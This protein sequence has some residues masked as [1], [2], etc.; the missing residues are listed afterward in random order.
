MKTFISLSVFSLMSAVVLAQN[1]LA[2]PPALSGATIDLELQNGTVQFF[3]GAATNT[4][5]ANGP[6]LGP[7]IILDRLQNVTMNVT[8]SLG[9]EATIHWHGMH[10]PAAADGGP[11]TVIPAGTTWSPSFQVLDKAATH[12]YHPHL[13]MNTNTQVQQG[14]AGMIIVRDPEEQAL[15]L[16]RSYGVDDF[17]IV[18]QTKAFDANN[19]II[20]E[21]ALDVNVMVNGTMDPY[22]DAPAQMIRLRLLNGASERTFNFGFTND[23]PFYQI[24]SDGSLLAAPVTHTRLD[25]SP[26]ERAEVVVD[27]SGMQ[28]QTIFLQSF[29]S[30]L[31]NAVYGATQPG[32]GAGQVIPN[33]TSNPLNGNDFNI[34]QINVVAATTDPVPVSALPATL[35]THTPWLA[36]EADNMR[37]FVFEPE[38][39]GPGAINGPF[40][41]NNAMFDMDIINEIVPLD[42]IEIWELTNMSPIGHPFHLHDVSFY[43]LTID[44]A[45][46]PAHLQG[47]KD[48]VFVPGGGSVVQFI[49]KFEDFADDMYPYMYHCHIL[50]HEDMGM[51]GQF[52][53]TENVG[54]DEKTPKDFAVYPN[55]SN[56]QI[57][58]LINQG[59][60]ATAYSIA[61]QSGRI[62]QS[63]EIPTGGKIWIDELENGIYIIRIGE[64]HKPEFFIK[65]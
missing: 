47:K 8:N 48:V 3:P 36:S 7:T 28:G 6:I 56:D 10:V 64:D 29:A 5:G 39:M 11:H 22:L 26:G 44:G 12:W 33:Y 65:N 30:E 58:L 60:F 13:H 51:M 42:N 52:I 40:M 4:K 1:P 49:T 59:L 27:L 45:A 24:A 62:V 54:L 19:Q 25:L 37:T 63:G 35:I 2:I 9:E 21:S 41:I 31:P 55:P 20:I 14:I 57:T 38:I 15:T 50:T 53:V 17:P 46:P 61:D 34:L 23:Q 43:I 16:P 32:M 18:V